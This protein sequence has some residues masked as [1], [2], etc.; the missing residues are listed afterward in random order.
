VSAWE[1]TNITSRLIL[2]P[3]L[4]LLLALIGLSLARSR[5]RFGAGI[6]LFS[7][8]AL[9]T[10]SIP[11]VGNRLVRLLEVPYSDPTHDPSPGAIVVLGGGSYVNA[12]EYEADT[13]AMATL[14]RL[15]YGAYL[16]R[17]TG[18][19]I[20]VSGGNPAGGATTEGEQMKNA[21]RDFGATAKWVESASDNTFE[22]AKFSRQTLKKAGVQSVYLVTN[23]WHMQRAQMAFERAGLHVIPAPMG[24]KTRGRLKP[25]DFIPTA[26]GLMD[27]SIFF[28]E[29]LG[30]V[31]YRL[32]FDLGR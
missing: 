32:K 17:R 18:K 15:R 4:F 29:V 3:A 23:A 24:Y 12:P 19:P 31:W 22:N 25:L 1:L 21:L 28:R 7:M 6:A 27:S 16:Q 10:L 30:M 8:L 20:L 26:H 5:M 14:E 11:V 2:P 13:V 9:F